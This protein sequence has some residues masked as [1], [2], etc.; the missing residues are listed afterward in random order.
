MF[1]P[2]SDYALNKMA[3]DAIIYTDAAGKVTRLTLADFASLEEFLRW[4]AW[5][6]ENYHSAENARANL[7]FCWCSCLTALAV[8]LT[9]RPLW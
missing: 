9:R 3:P 7:I 4:K 8:S 5:S 1:D 6:D 2:R